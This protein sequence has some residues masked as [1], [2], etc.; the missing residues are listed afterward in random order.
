MKILWWFAAG[1]GAAAG[2]AQVATWRRARAAATGL[3][4]NACSREELLGL[5]GMNNDFADR[6]LENRPYRS[7]FDLLNRLI[8]P[9]SVY[10]RLRSQV[11]VDEAASHK[12]VQ[13]A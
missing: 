2:L 7:K 8:I 4:L 1:L 13:I 5:P 3:D 6:V 9:D 10:S 12:T 11:R